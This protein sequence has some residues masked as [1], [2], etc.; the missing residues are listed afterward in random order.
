MA[1]T[2]KNSKAVE[3]EEFRAEV[4]NYIK[5]GKSEVLTAKEKAMLDKTRPVKTA[6]FWSP[7]VEYFKK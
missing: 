6:G 1:T 3:I 4:Q 2:A 7:V 5:T